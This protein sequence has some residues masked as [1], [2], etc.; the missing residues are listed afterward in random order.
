[1]DTNRACAYF[2]LVLGEW[3]ELIA[4]RQ[5]VMSGDDKSSWE[6]TPTP[7][8]KWQGGY[9]IDLGAGLSVTPTSSSPLTSPP[10]P[11]KAPDQ[12]VHGANAGA[13][14]PSAEQP[15][16]M[17]SD[18]ALLLDIALYPWM[19]LV[20]ALAFAVVST[21]NTVT[22][23]GLNMHWLFGVGA[24]VL[25][26]WIYNA[27]MRILPTMLALAAPSALLSGL[28]AWALSDSAAARRLTESVNWNA[29]EVATLW[30]ALQS[31]PP[32]LNGWVIAAMLLNLAAHIAFWWNGKGA[33]A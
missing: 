17:R 25:T 6:V 23:L 15:A 26:I 13:A 4:R 16:S 32:V 24:F 29:I 9:R 10:K 22:P 27:L 18:V 33:R 11:N 2:S 7:L 28:I 19:L 30:S 21:P 20:G 12:P 8:A 1:M 31:H 3:P 5:A 14:G